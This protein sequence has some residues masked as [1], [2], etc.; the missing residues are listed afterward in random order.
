M[1]SSTFRQPSMAKQGIQAAVSLQSCFLPSYNFPLAAL[2]YGQAKS[3]S[4]PLSQEMPS[5]APALSQLQPLT[6][7]L[8]DRRKHCVSGV[9]G[10]QLSNLGNYLSQE[11]V[12][13]TGLISIIL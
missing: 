5:L 12:N 4:P 11:T 10:F 9:G 13:Q 7:R 2:G 1:E 3:I 6:T 8:G